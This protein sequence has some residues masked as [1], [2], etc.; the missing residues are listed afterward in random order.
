MSAN[1]VLPPVPGMTRAESSENF[2]GVALKRLSLCQSMLPR[3]N[4]RLRSSRA[5]TLPSW[6]RLE[7]SFTSIDSRRAC[8]L[9]DVAGGQ[10]QRAEMPAEGD[11]L[12]VVD[13]L[14]AED[15]HAV[16]VHA[17]PRS[18]RPRR[19]TDAGADVDARDL[20][21]EVRAGG[22]G[23]ADG[24]GHGPGS[25]SRG[26]CPFWRAQLSPGGAGGPCHRCAPTPTWRHCRS[27]AQVE[28]RGR[29]PVQTNLPKGTS[30]SLISIQ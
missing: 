2:A 8:A 19:R 15:Q 26:L 20:A 13:L 4:S 3:P 22:V 18:R 10:F 28:Q 29:S 21:D 17:R 23:G 25:S 30:R 7:M 5:M 9:D 1:S 16:A 14:A 6:S 24:E 12:R 11:L 27:K